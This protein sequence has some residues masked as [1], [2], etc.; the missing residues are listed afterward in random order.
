MK[1]LRVYP[2]NSRCETD[3]AIIAFCKVFQQNASA[4]IYQ[5][6][7]SLMSFEDKIGRRY[8]RIYEEYPYN[9]VI[10]RE[11][12]SRKALATSFRFGGLKWLLKNLGNAIL[13]PLELR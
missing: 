12:Y 6:A 13:H 8:S 4:A 5:L 3:G 7:Y 9:G 11:F 2:D 10:C 1:G